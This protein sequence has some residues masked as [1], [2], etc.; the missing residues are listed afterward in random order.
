M[1]A[2]DAANKLDFAQALQTDSSSTAD[3]TYFGFA[4][5]GTATSEAKWGIMKITVTSGDVAVTWALGS[6][7]QKNIWDIRS[8]TAES[9]RSRWSPL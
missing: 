5:A 1:S 7:D 8:N 3:T 4:C 6:P 9:R 2:R